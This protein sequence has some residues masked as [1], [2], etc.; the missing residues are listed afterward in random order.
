[1]KKLPVCL[2]CAQTGFLCINCQDKVDNGEITEFDVE[3]SKE[4]IQLEEKYPRLRDATF[5]KTIDFGDIV[6]LVVGSGDRGK[7]T[8]ELV[9]DLKETFGLE[10]VQV[11]EFSKNVTRIVENLVAP[12]KLKGVNQLFLPMGTTE[13]KARVYAEDKDLLPLPVEDIE[14][15]VQELTGKVTRITFE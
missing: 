3:L 4:L 5:V 9:H 14:D 13:Y 1:M 7:Y 8:P 10:R 12:A 6:L 2:V 11:V 15:I